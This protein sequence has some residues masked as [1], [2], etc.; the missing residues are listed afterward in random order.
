VAETGPPTH[1]VAQPPEGV[2]VPNQPAQPT[3]GGVV[4]HPAHNAVSPW[5]IAISVM[6][7]TFM[8]VLDT[9]IVNVSLPHIAGTL[10]ASIEES[11]WALTTYL[12]ANAIIL[13]ITGWLANYF[14]RRRVLLL[15]V[16]GFTT[17]SVLCGMAT[18][19]PMLVLWRFLQGMTGGVLQP[20]SQAIMLEAFEPKDRGK[21]MAFFGLGIVVAP[22]LGPVLGGWLTDNYSWR[23]V[24]Y[25][26]VPFGVA[27]YLMLRANV[28]DP[29]YIK[30][31]SAG[32]DYWGIGLLAVGIAALQIGLDQGQQKDWF[33]SDLIITLAIIA[34]V[35]LGGFIWH[36]LTTP[37]P[38]VDL[39][40]FKEP[41]FA[42]SVIL[43]TAMGFGL[44]GSMV[45][46]P[47]LLQTLLGYPSLQAGFAMA[48]R[49]LGSLVAMPVV[50]LLMN[51]VDPRKMLV[52][53][54]LVSA[55]TLWWMGWLN[56]EAGFWDVFWP[57]FVQGIGMG[58][59][60][61]PLT[62]IAMDRIAP[63]DMGSATSLFNLLRNI[64]GAAG[65]SYVQ[66]IL[67]RDRQE[68]FNILG[69]HISQY[70]PS[71]QLMFQNLRSAFIA[72][73]ADAVT[74]TERAYAAMSGM[75]Q[76]QAAMI[77]FLDAFKMLAFVFVVLLPLVFLMRKPQHHEASAAIIAE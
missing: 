50:G 6:F 17:A 43:T 57:Q 72:R 15:S 58:L 22:V 71:S 60:F 68:H 32:I 2:G 51:R 49:G 1:H 45:V 65:I 34:A 70:T 69:A 52:L 24:F 67:A 4:D 33:S 47:V 25:V 66:T 12:A 3:A 10:S 28:F 26:N 74:A 7:G 5:V 18:S 42:T 54:F 64:G 62:T 76:K 16:A 56:L 14:G 63:Q 48:P 27:A 39:R 44:Y 9:T 59:L 8:V 11:T 31:G 37:A 73:G 55:A 13:P 53:G 29:P 35:G 61:V 36:A 23:W 75:V 41:T 20:L 38:V 46:M 30:R 77:A 40:L 21:A 19:L